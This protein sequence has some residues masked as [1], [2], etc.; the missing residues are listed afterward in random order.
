NEIEKA[1]PFW[2]SAKTWNEISL[3]VG[4]K[5][6]EYVLSDVYPN[7]QAR[8]FSKLQDLASNYYTNAHLLGMTL[9]ADTTV[10]DKKKY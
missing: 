7:G 4:E 10:Y 8:I 2:S 1:M 5:S 3:G 9:N 6:V